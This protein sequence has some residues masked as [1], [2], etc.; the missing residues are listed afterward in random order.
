MLRLCAPGSDE[1][2]Q[3]RSCVSGYPSPHREGWVCGVGPRLRSHIKKEK[4]VQH[5]E[6]GRGRIHTGRS[7]SSCPT[8]YPC[9][10]PTAS[11]GRAHFRERDHPICAALAP[12]GG[13]SSHAH[14]HQHFSPF[15]LNHMCFPFPPI[16]F[17]LSSF[18]LERSK[19]SG[20]CGKEREKL[21][22]LYARTW[23]CHVISL[24]RLD[25]SK[26]NLPLPHHPRKPPRMCLFPLIIPHPVSKG[27]RRSGCFMVLSLICLSLH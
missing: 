6:E 21:S 1:T 3:Q 18:P 11:Q 26:H 22:T 15:L 25:E 16:S 17:F 14:M 9:S 20:M 8:C 27:E 7:H 4:E 10:F 23:S 24:P 19:V 5:H 13:S 12:F 2:T